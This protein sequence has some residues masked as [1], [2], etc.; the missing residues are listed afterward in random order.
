MWESMWTVFLISFVDLVNKILK[1]F[2]SFPCMSNL[3]K[4]IFLVDLYLLASIVICYLCFSFYDL[5]IAK[6]EEVY[7]ILL[8]PIKFYISILEKTHFLIL[9]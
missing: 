8:F 5:F 4:Y 6:F 9:S 1:F 3:D 2:F 7:R